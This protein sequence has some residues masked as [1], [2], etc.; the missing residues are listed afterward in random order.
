MLLN[1]PFIKAILYRMAES[2]KSFQIGGIE[3]EKDWIIG[4]L[5]H[6]VYSR[7]I[8]CVPL[9]PAA[10]FNSLQICQPV[11][12]VKKDLPPLIA[13]HD[14]VAERAFKFDMRLSRHAREYIFEG[15]HLGQY[16]G[17]TFYKIIYVY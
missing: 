5:D 9:A 10:L 16:S 13:T 17:L 12:I 8:I 6:Q 1:A 7:S 11:P 3:A 14:N 4:C 15:H 2:R